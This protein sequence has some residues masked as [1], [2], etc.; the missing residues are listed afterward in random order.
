VAE[1]EGWRLAVLSEGSVSGSSVS[2][3]SVSGSHASASELCFRPDG[4][5]APTDARH[6]PGGKRA[7]PG[8]HQRPEPPAVTQLS[9][10]PFASLL[11]PA[12]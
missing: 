11:V 1:R 12:R 8:T 2:G 9:D 3:S 10:L 7:E 5:L 4:S 6:I